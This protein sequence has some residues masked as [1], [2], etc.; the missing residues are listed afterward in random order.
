ML[1]TSFSRIQF[2]TSYIWKQIK[3]YLGINGKKMSQA[4]LTKHVEK[5]H[6]SV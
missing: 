4:L 6:L 2:Y 5:M 1:V 3:K